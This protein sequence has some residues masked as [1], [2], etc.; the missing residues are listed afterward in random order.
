[1]RRVL[2][3]LMLVLS[4]SL[5]A[6]EASPVPDGAKWIIHVE[7]R[8]IIGGDL[9]V[10][11]T[12]VAA[13]PEAVAGLAQIE[14]VFG[15]KLLS[16]IQA[17]TI[18]GEDASEEKTVLAIRGTF[19][20]TKLTALVE[21]AGQHVAANYANRNIHT[22]HDAE[23]NKNPFACLAADNLLLVGNSD[24]MLRR[25]IDAF[26][27]KTPA[28]AIGADLNTPATLAFC[29]VRD[30]QRLQGADPKAAILRKVTEL[31][32]HADAKD[33]QLSV[34]LE[35]R[36]LD[37]AA[38]KNVKSIAEGLRALAVLNSQQDAN[39]ASVA[40]K[41]QILTEGAFVR[42]SLSIAS[43][44]ATAW[45]EDRMKEAAGAANKPGV[46]ATPGN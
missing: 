33:K 41:I 38:A 5:R 44:A 39:M 37:E 4:V 2:L 12:Q 32:A 18:F 25:C 9:G 24:A 11:I 19:D 6:G 22:W 1:M 40:E 26:D 29:A 14:A 16:D 28:A 36:T 3:I 42:V 45:L 20:R 21:K 34:A 7:C 23:K 15:V 43:D 27:A 46:L 30:L 8:K 17:V 31:R 13:K 35:A 10:F